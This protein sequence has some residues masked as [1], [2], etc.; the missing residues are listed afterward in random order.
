[1][2]RKYFYLDRRRPVTAFHRRDHGS[3]RSGEEFGEENL[4]AFD[5]ANRAGTAAELNGKVVALVTD[6]CG[7]RFQDGATLVVVAAR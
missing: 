5:G 2:S 4:A 7:G 6:F 3:L 1:M